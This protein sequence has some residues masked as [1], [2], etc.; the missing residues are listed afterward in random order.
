MEELSIRWV[1]WDLSRTSSRRT[2]RAMCLEL[3]PF[4]HATG[5]SFLGPAD[6][7]A[8]SDQRGDLIIR[9]Q[10]SL[11]YEAALLRVL[12][13]NRVCDLARQSNVHAEKVQQ[14]DI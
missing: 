3:A 10:S 12:A 7:K 4:L 14:A 9:G 1:T 5:Y 8:C 11:A 6:Q 2:V 13:A